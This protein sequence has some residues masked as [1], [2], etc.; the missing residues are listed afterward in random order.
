MENTCFDCKYYRKNALGFGMLCD[1]EREFY[2][3]APW[4]KPACKHFEAAKIEHKTVVI[5]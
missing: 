4:D 1:K 3:D 5:K 2:L